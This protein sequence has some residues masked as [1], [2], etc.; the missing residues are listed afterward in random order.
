MSLPKV[1]REGN[2]EKV[3]ELIAKGAP[4]NKADVGGWT[5]LIH[6]AFSGNTE[7]ANMLIVAGA[8]LEVGDK[9]FKATALMY[10]CGHID[11]VL[12]LL[13]AKVN[14][15]ARDNQGMTALMWASSSGLVATVKAL[16]SEGADTELKDD[17]GMTAVAWA[18]TTGHTEIAELLIGAKLNLAQVI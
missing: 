3:K 16:I 17:D 9:D 12:M 1:A 18:T 8:D 5:A 6:V 11:I 13:D 2:A 14:V 7:I 15:D 4:L 10:A